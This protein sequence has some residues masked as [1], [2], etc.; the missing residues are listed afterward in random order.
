[1]LSWESIKNFL[2]K[3]DDTMMLIKKE[4]NLISFLKIEWSLFVKTSSKDAL[5]QVCLKLAQ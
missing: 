4:K 3:Y 2:Q 1:M 5:R